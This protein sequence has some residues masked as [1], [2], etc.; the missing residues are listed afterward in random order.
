VYANVPDWVRV[1]PPGPESV[2]FSSYVPPDLLG[3]FEEAR[4]IIDTS[5]KASAM[6]SRRCLQRIIREQIGIA[7]QN[8]DR[9]IQSVLPSNR[10]PSYLADDLNAVSSDGTVT[11]AC[12]E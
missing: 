4:K 9:E 8:L 1:Y 11:S 5:P 12:F 2:D 10:L 3:D 7:G 6:L